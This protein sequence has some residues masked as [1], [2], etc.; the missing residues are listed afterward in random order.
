[1]NIIYEKTG[2]RYHHEVHVYRLLHKWGFSPKVPK[3]KFVNAASKEEKDKFRKRL[4]K[5]IFIHDAIV[6]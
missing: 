5:S 2:V 3:K 1:M 6:S 4:K